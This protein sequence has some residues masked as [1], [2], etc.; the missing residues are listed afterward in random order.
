MLFLSRKKETNTI[1][2]VAK[3]STYNIVSKMIEI[4]D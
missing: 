3:G 4:V 1:L 2:F